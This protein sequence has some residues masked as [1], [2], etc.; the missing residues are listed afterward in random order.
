MRSKRMSVGAALE[1]LLRLI[2]RRAMKLSVLPEDERDPHYDLIR[3]SCCA[4][5]ERIGQSPDQ[6]A[7]TANDMVE[8][9]RALVGIIE[10][11]CGPDHG[12]S[13]GQPSPIQRTGGQESGTTRI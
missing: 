8:F 13:A 12:R 1:Q 10:V 3:L 6:A 2:Y 4:A 7:I 5:A 11:G 9:V